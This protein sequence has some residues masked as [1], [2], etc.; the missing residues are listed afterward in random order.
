MSSHFETLISATFNLRFTPSTLTFHCFGDLPVE[1]QIQIWKYAA[2]SHGPISLI[3]ETLYGGDRI[4]HNFLRQVS[5]SQ[6][7]RWIPLE[8]DDE[9][10]IPEVGV[11]GDGNSEKKSYT[12]ARVSKGVVVREWKRAVSEVHCEGE[13]RRERTIELLDG[14][15]FPWKNEGVGS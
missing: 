2:S 8:P 5:P 9:K 1:I 7:W 12:D 10:Y 14:F 6:I 15:I 3:P 4:R 11:S 13:W